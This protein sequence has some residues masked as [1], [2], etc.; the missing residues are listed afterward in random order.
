MTKPNPYEPP[1]EGPNPAATEPQSMQLVLGLC[2]I[3]ICFVLPPAM[4]V[5]ILKLYGVL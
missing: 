4:L 3:I 5:I 1:K 2:V